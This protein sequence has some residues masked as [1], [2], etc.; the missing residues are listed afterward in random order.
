MESKKTSIEEERSNFGLRLKKA[1]EHSE[2]SQQQV[3]DRFGCGKGTVSAWETGRGDPGVFKL[4]HLADLYQVTASEL[5]YAG[6]E[7]WPFQKVDQDRYEALDE[8]ARAVAQTRM[9]DEVEKQE[10][11]NKKLRANGTNR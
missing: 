8:G 9:M 4:R 1:R 2:L 7:I 3:G 11:L 10:A 6:K 5:I